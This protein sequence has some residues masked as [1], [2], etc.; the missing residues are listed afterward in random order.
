[1]NVRIRILA[2]ATALV[3]S[4]A[5][6]PALGAGYKFTTVNGPASNVGGTHLAAV[7]N[8]GSV[9]G[10][11]HDSAYNAQG[12]FGPPSGKLTS[13]GLLPFGQGLFSPAQAVITGINDYDEV[14][15]DIPVQPRTHFQGFMFEFYQGQFISIGV[16]SRLLGAPARSMNDG[17]VIAGSFRPASGKTSGFTL[18]VWNNLTAFDAT[19]WTTWTAAVGIN[20]FG[21]VVGQY[22]AVSSPSVVTAGFLRSSGG[23]ITPLPT[24][25]SI[26]GVA[27][28][29]GGIYYNGINDNG[30]TVGAF[31]DPNNKSYG[32]VRDAA[33]NFRLI[34][35]PGAAATA[36]VVGINNSGTI[37]GNYF[38][39]AGVEHGF[40]GVPA[41]AP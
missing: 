36:G 39:G 24:P 10:V 8:N 34:Q 19:P 18:D 30:V 33:G 13:L 23:R 14:L 4:F 16:P 25:R 9:A 32:F 17:D 26:G 40:I 21:T 27:V 29:S 22:A 41:T 38:D 7:N 20:N 11:T 15:G 3:G 12:F 37:V 28:G 35:F 5:T 1:M 2:A 31:A 6:G